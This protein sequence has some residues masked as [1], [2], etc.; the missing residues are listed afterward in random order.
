[1]L[2]PDAN[3]LIYAFNT[4]APLHEEARLWWEREVNRG[5]PLGVA[6][7]VFSAFVRLLTGRQIVE[8]PYTAVEIF[9]LAESWWE[10]PNVTL[11]EPTVET[12]RNFRTLME[13]GRLAGS[14]TTDAWIAAHVMEHRGRLI[15]NDTDFIRFPEIRTENPFST[16]PRR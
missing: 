13:R 16:R 11:V 2:F 5:T 9:E 14:A 3:V 10:R 7:P 15:T 1:M 12:Y 4:S 6:W 8:N